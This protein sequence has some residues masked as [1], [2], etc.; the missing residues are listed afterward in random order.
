MKKLTLILAALLAL[1]AAGLYFGLG[2]ALSSGVMIG[3]N[4]LGPQVTQTHVELAAARLSPFSGRGTL[5]G[6]VVGNPPGWSADHAFTLGKIDIKVNLRSLRGDVIEIEEIVIEQPE[7]IY[8]TRLVNSNL[9]AL[10]KNIE[11]FTGPSG[12]GT[13]PA[14]APPSKPRK[15]IVRKFRLS[16]A[17][18]TLGVGPAA[19]PVPLPALELNNLGLDKGGAT[20]AELSGEVL[21]QVLASIVRAAGTA[22]INAGAAAGRG[23]GEAI[24]GGLKKLFGG[25]SKK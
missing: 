16:E 6:L 11:S 24:G 8:E 9:K 13:P 20:P 10:L 22:P 2:P 4:N 19:L 17:K 21:A 15:F 12:S 25:S 5:T 18:A 7:F 23:T 14:N 1:G 3:V